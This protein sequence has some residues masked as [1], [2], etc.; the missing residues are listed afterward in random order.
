M[1]DRAVETVETMTL[2]HFRIL[3]DMVS[4]FLSRD[5]PLRSCWY[6][7]LWKP[8]LSDTR[9]SPRSPGHT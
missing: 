3:R 6:F 5:T 4:E 8:V 2:T 9:D 7:G 1:L